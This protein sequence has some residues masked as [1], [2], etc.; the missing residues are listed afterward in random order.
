MSAMS[1]RALF[2][3]VACASLASC[4]TAPASVPIV[5]V[6]TSGALVAPAGGD[7]GGG[8]LDEARAW[9]ELDMHDRARGFAIAEVDVFAEIEIAPGRCVLVDVALPRGVTD[10]DLEAYDVE[11]HRLALDR[12]GAR[13]AALAVC[14]SPQAPMKIHVRALAANGAGE[15]AIRSAELAPSSPVLEVLEPG[16]RY[17]A[18]ATIATR[19]AERVFASFAARGFTSHDG[20]FEADATDAHILFGL[21]TAPGQCIAIVARATGHAT[22][23]IATSGASPATAIRDDGTDRDLVVEACE[24]GTEGATVRIDA[25]VGA[26]VTWVVLRGEAVRVGGEA[27]LRYGSELGA[28][29]ER[30]R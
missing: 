8:D 21:A 28:R 20:P 30:A 18:G 13:F 22:L 12:T 15:L 17:E 7:R 14:A 3:V 16:A 1:A 27:A 29:P 11:G 9:P 24:L 5:T 25:N 2:G 6:G 26:H 23:T 19:F 10:A 4:A